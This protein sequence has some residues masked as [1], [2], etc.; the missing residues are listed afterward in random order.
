MKL[1]PVFVVAP[2][3]ES[4]GMM[5]TRRA[6]LLALAAGAAGVSLGGGGAFLL[7]RA[8]GKR[9]RHG[10]Q[11]AERM[12][13]WARKLAV[14]GTPDARLL[15][16]SGPLLMTMA[17]FAP[18]DPQLWQAVR[19]VAKTVVGDKDVSDRVQ[20]ACHVRKTVIGLSPP[21]FLR[22][23]ELIPEL[24]AVINSGR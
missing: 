20:I 12:L 16:N 2:R 8:V 6:L 10:G 3:H 7:G 19:R 21:A 9:E 23:D 4:K 14:P 15:E 1:E 11:D 24:D 17:E 5:P 22:F 18:D 13:A